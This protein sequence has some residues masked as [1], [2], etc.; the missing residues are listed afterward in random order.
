[1]ERELGVSRA[2]AAL[3]RAASCP[4]SKLTLP[5][6]SGD[7]HSPVRWSLLPEGPWDGD[8]GDVSKVISV[9]TRAGSVGPPAHPSRETECWFPGPG[10]GTP[11]TMRLRGHAAREGVPEG[12][13]PPPSHY[14]A[15]RARRPGSAARQARAGVPAVVCRGSGNIT[16]P[17]RPVCS[18]AKWDA[19][20]PGPWGHCELLLL[21]RWS[22]SLMRPVLGAPCAGTLR[23]ESRGEPPRGSEDE[24]P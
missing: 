4:I 2:P 18:P 19:A 16:C 8:G 9:G 1:M 5:G 23:G 15:S 7:P 3:T 24:A 20:A 21:R 14:G 10:Q 13:P 22:H 11:E 17:C 12:P 6:T